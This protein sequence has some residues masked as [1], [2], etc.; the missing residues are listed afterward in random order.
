MIFFIR[1]K[2]DQ[3][4]Y[5]LQKIFRGYSDL[6]VWGFY[7]YAA[8]YS[9]PRLK[10]MRKDLHGHP[11]DMSITEWET[12]LDTIIY[13]MESIVKDEFGDV[14]GVKYVV[15]WEEVQEGCELLGKYFTHLWD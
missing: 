8:K 7:T 15:D 1:H 5:L 4:Q 12:I 10:A 11:M 6:E 13:A 2:I 9:L 14:D 3:V